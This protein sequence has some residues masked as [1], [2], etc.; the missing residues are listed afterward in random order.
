[1]NRMSLMRWKE[2]HSSHGRSG[3]F[4]QRKG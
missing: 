3:H 1:L 2:Y 4:V